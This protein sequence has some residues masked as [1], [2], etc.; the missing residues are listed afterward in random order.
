MFL[1]YPSTQKGYKL[2]NFVTNKVF[3]SRDVVFHEHI[4]PFRESSLDKYKYPAPSYLPKT[5]SP[6]VWVENDSTTQNDSHQREES[7]PLDTAEHYDDPATY[8]NNASPSPQPSLV[9]NEPSAPLRTSSR[10]TKR[11]A[12]MNDYVTMNTVRYLISD[13]LTYTNISPDYRAYLTATAH[14]TD[15]VNFST[16]VQDIK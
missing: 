6:Q 3:V 12:W 13:N 15:P 2:L 9:P 10:V 1:G 11:P 16:V 5:L 4:F 14:Y 7:Q 8:G